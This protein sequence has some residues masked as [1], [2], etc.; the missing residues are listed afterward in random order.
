MV[1][2]KKTRTNVFAGVM[3]N[4]QAGLKAGHYKNLSS[5]LKSEHKKA[6]KLYGNR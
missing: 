3:Q 5:A 4:A 6:K 2:H 1:Y